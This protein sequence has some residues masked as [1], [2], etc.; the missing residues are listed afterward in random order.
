MF[1][2]DVLNHV[3]LS[4]YYFMRR[5]PDVRIVAIPQHEWRQLVRQQVS[6]NARG[7]TPRSHRVREA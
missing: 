3:G 5:H 4:R 7:K 6:P 2:D 1:F